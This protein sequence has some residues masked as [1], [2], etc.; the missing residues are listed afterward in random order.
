M[1]RKWM[2]LAGVLGAAVL[3]LAAWHCLSGSRPFR[4]LRAEEVQFATVQLS[5][6]DQTLVVSDLEALTAYLRELVIYGE[7]DSYTEYAGQAAVFT[8]TMSDGTETVVTAYAPFLII[9]GV[10]YRTRHEPCE[11]LNRYANKLAESGECPV[12]L[13]EPPA[14]AVVSD[15]ISHRAL[16]GAYTWQRG[17]P[18]GTTTQLLADAPHPLD[19]RELL[20]PLETTE[21][22]AVL[23]FTQ[24]PDRVTG[25]RCWSDTGQ[26]DQSGEA[27]TLRGNEFSL[28]PGG[29]IYEVTAV[30][31]AESGW[32]GTAS[33]VFFIKSS[34]AA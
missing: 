27:L 12:V 17:N 5:P 30:W 20:E 1:K 9:D 33:Y 15:R 31:D 11:A 18:D 29:C 26:T 25:V 13:E 34:P 32:G 3:G 7:D 22:T 10:G 21:A 16:L 24:P 6:P 23:Q 8:L 2:V 19:C 28:R 14:L 4:Q